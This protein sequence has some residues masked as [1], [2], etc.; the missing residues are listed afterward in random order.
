MRF[1]CSVLQLDYFHAGNSIPEINA[2]STPNIWMSVIMLLL[3]VGD[4]DALHN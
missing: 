1:S 3:T 2:T 4:G